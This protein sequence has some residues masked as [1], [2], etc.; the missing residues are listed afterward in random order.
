MT[1]I[2]YL[3]LDLSDS[4]PD[5]GASPPI[6]PATS[7]ERAMGALEA[8]WP[9]VI[10]RLGDLVS[11][12]D[13]AEADAYGVHEVAFELGIEAGVRFGLTASANAAIR[14]TFRRRP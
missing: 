2:D 3:I 11:A 1:K 5:G 13:G 14:V 9:Q 12:A 10:R 7:G 4:A 8:A 6:A